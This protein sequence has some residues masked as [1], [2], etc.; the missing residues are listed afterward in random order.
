MCDSHKTVSVA[1]NYFKFCF[2]EIVNC[3]AKFFDTQST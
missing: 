1:N 2:V 3:N